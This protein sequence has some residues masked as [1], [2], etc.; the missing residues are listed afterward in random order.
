MAI[1]EDDTWHVTLVGRFGAYPPPD[2]ASFF[3]FAKSLHTPRLYYLIKDAE[4]VS[5][6]TYY[7]FPT[8]VLRH[9]ERLATLPEG[10][11]VLGDAIGSFSPVYG[12]GMSFADHGLAARG[13]RPC[14][15]H[16]DCPMATNTIRRAP[17]QGAG[18][19]R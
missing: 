19:T 1:I 18:T 15:L 3:A 2:E 7:R 10:F 5:D 4:R 6:I 17:P 13:G 14:L 11:V 9:Y 12:Q 8:S 16:G